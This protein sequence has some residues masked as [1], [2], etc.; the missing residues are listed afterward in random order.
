M[1]PYRVMARRTYEGVELLA[2]SGSEVIEEETAPGQ[3]RMEILE[4][5]P[6]TEISKK[7]YTKWFDYDKI[8]CN[9]QIRK[10]QSG[11]YLIIDSAGHRQKLKNYLVNEK[12]PQAERDGLWLL[13][14]GSHI[15]WVIGHRMSDYYKVDEHTKRVLEVQYDGGNEDE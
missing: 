10:R 2:K 8:E 11:D 7:K 14:D 13:A 6:I 12:I 1:L 15:M 5:V 3:I 9:V 4:H